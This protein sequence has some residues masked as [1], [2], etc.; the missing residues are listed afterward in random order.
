[1][2]IKIQNKLEYNATFYLP[3]VNVQYFLLFLELLD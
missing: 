2:I 3:M 1:M